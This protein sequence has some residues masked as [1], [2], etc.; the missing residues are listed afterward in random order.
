MYMCIIDK[1]NFSEWLISDLALDLAYTLGNTF[2]EQ[3][4]SWLRANQASSAST[5]VEFFQIFEL[6]VK[7]MFAGAPVCKSLGIKLWR[8]CDTT[9]YD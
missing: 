6:F 5:K 3:F 8:I 4:E 9:S 1:H 2:G 7:E